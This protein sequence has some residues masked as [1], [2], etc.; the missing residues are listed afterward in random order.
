MDDGTNFSDTPSQ[1]AGLEIM[2]DHDDKV[3][4][5]LHIPASQCDRSIGDVPAV[6][7]LA[8]WRRNGHVFSVPCA[9]RVVAH[10]PCLERWR[11]LMH[12]LSSWSV[13]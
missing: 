3:P 2:F 9:T 10:L 11:P 1:N 12:S 7:T 13:H 6:A 8:V 5:A 4:F